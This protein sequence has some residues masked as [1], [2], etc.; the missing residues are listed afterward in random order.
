MALNGDQE[1]TPIAVYFEGRHSI[2]AE[3]CGTCS[4]E[5]AGR[6]VPV[7]MCAASAARM[8]DN[9]LPAVMYLDRE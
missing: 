5:Q 8:T 9:Q 4:D 1:H 7:T 3:V 6:W 2:P